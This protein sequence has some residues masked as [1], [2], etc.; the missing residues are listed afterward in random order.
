MSASVLDACAFC[1]RLCRHVCPVAV[2]TARESATP[3]A[4]AGVVRLAEHGVLEATL[5][6]QALDLCVGCGA[7][8]R[9][10]ALHVD[11]AA[12]VRD[13][14]TPPGV[15]PLPELPPIDAGKAVR[16]LVTPPV[17]DPRASSVS[18]AALTP[19]ALGHAA[20]L[21]GNSAVLAEVARHFAGRRVATDS[22][23]VAEVLLAA[24]VEVVRSAAPDGAARFRTC[25]EGA[26]GE[27]GQL[28]CCGAREGFPE[29]NP[30]AAHALAAEVVRRMNGAPHTCAD[31]HCAG[32]LRA[33][34]ADVRG[35]D[36]D[37][38][39]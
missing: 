35:P 13:C 27:D 15:A 7:C 24:G 30:A 9:Y 22:A 14:R 31:G 8:T 20:W 33:H 11:V 1:P 39:G 17:G 16:V 4:I 38:P 6:D 34:G 19:D 21:A 23:A 29:R 2:G 5:A 3:T 12:W 25:S 32:W 26:L 10:C 37:Q 36:A 18:G 28:S